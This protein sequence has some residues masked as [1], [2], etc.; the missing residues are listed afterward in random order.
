MPC[1]GSAAS[2]PEDTIRS[3]YGTLL[4]T[5][6]SGAT[7][8][9][10]GRYDQ[11]APAIQQDFDLPYMTQMAVG[12]A[13]R[14]LSDVEKQQMSE[15]FARYIAATYTDNFDRYSGEKFEVT[16]QQATPYGTIVRSR[17]VKSDGEPVIM[18]YLM[19]QNQGEWQVG[20]IYLT[21]VISQVATLRSQFTSVLAREGLAGLI[22][23]LNSKVANLTASPVSVIL[24]TCRL[25]RHT[26]A[27]PE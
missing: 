14:T 8:G 20:D 27:L 7:L 3:F 15:A 16:G 5:M 13:W 17:I 2:S 1:V 4:S 6:K 25:C 24:R 19:R 23:L 22:T 18:N 11:I 9:A 12:P 21:G 26:N 10:R